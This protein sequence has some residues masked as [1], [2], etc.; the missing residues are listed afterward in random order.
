M[1]DVNNVILDFINASINNGVAQEDGN[2]NQANKFYRVIEKRTK[3]LIDHNELCN[4]LFLELL[5]HENDY[6]RFHTSCALLHIESDD[7]LNTLLEL[8][9]KRGL[10]GFSSKMTISEYRKGNI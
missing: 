5:H 8:T 10:L 7:A 4:P 1:N 3:W 9:E 2:A 6:V